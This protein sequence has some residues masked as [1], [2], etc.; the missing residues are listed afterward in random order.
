M[1]KRIVFAVGG[2]VLLQRFGRHRHLDSRSYQLTSYK[3][4]LQKIERKTKKKNV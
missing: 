2:A 4:H 3:L 1:E